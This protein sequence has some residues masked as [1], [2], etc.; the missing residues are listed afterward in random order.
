MKFASAVYLIVPTLLSTASAAHSRLDK[1][2]AVG[3]FKIVQDY[4]PTQ[5]RNN[6]LAHAA[7]GK[8]FTLPTILTT[9]AETGPNG[10]LPNEI[11]D[12][13]PNAPLVQRN[14]E[15]NAWDNPEFRA[16]VE[17]TGKKQIILAGITTD[18]CTVFL[19][20]SLRDAG[21]DVWANSEASGTFDERVAADANGRMRDAGVHLVSTFAVIMDLMRD[22]RNTPGAEQ[23]LPFI[24][25]YA[26]FSVV[27]SFPQE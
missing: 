9:S 5:F 21:Y 11:L 13:H 3:L 6:M 16:A 10:P 2:N 20:L 14:G 8:L 4:H 12:L 24:D 17:A 23:L 7:V 26:C 22:W 19:A 25:R 27:D 18:V 1:E 15:V